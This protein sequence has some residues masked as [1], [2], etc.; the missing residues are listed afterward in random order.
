[1]IEWCL[2]FLSPP[3][4]YVPD[5]AARMAFAVQAD[6]PAP[7][8]APSPLQCECKCKNGVVTKADGHRVECPCPQTCPCKSK[9]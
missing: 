8:P 4:D 6:A 7:A 5:V 9:R 1:M 2:Y 3:R